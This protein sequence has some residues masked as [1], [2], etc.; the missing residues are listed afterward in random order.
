MIVTVIGLLPLAVTK[1]SA[2][3]ALDAETAVQQSR[4]VDEPLA[5]KRFLIDAP[6]YTAVLRAIRRH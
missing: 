1:T 5:I 6:G 4:R 2:D 3:Q